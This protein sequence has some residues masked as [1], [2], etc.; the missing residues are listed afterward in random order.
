MSW[1]FSRFG[2]ICVICRSWVLTD[3]RIIRLQFVSPLQFAKVYSE[4][5]VHLPHC[6]FVNDYKQV[7]L[8]YDFKF[9]LY[10]WTGWSN[11]VRFL[12]LANLCQKNR[13]V[14]DPSCLPKRSDYGL[15]EDKFIFACFNQLYKM[16]PDIFNTWYYFVLISIYWLC[17]C[18][19]SMHLDNLVFCVLC[20]V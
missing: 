7:G 4:K 3:L 12:H 11:T 5:L 1:F 20:Q 14:L 8:N 19:L 13:E 17:S 10:A 9:L 15:P 2:F 18:S 16:D 6:Y